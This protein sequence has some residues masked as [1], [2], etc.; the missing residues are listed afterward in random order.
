[1][2]A[3]QFV[4]NKEGALCRKDTGE[5][6]R[7]DYRRL[8]R[9]IN[10]GRELR[11]VIRFGD[12]DGEYPLL[13]WTA[14]GEVIIP[15]SLS[16]NK[17]DLKGELRRIRDATK[18]RIMY[19]EAYIEGP[20]VE[21]VITGTT[22]VAFEDV[23]DFEESQDFLDELFHTSAE[24]PLLSGNFYAEKTHEKKENQMQH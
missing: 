24:P 2:H 16:V 4:V 20:S 6:V 13:F 21:C 23:P 11:S 3:E 1:M 22:V 17:S 9:E 5:V 8:I 19:A 18:D 7:I 12:R 14:D 15:T 10:N